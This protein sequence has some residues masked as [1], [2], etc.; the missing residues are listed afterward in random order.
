MPILQF[1]FSGRSTK[2][3]SEEFRTRRVQIHTHVTDLRHAEQIFDD[4]LVIS[5]FEKEPGASVKAKFVPE[6]VE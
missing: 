3:P 5:G 4:W 6:P 1:S 2:G